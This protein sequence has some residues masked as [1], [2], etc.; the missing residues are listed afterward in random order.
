[1]KN[2]NNILIL[3]SIII[4]VF[5]F[6]NC[7]NLDMFIDQQKPSTN[8]KW[9][10]NEKTNTYQNDLIGKFKDSQVIKEFTNESTG[11]KLQIIN[12]TLWVKSEYNS[13][14]EYQIF[15]T[16]Q[17]ENTFSL[18][19]GYK[20]NNS[21]NN[22]SH[23]ILFNKKLEYGIY[24]AKTNK[25]WELKTRSLVDLKIVDNTIIVGIPLSEIRI[26][27]IANV[28]FGY[29]D[30]KSKHLINIGTNLDISY[31]YNTNTQM[32][33]YEYRQISL[34]NE[35]SFNIFQGIEDTIIAYTSNLLSGQDTIIELYDATGTLLDSNDDYLD[36][37]SQIDYKVN[38]DGI[39]IIKV[40]S[41][42]NRYI[43][44]YDLSLF[45]TSPEK[46]SFDTN[47]FTEGF[48][49]Q[50][51]TTKW[52]LSSSNAPTIQTDYK[53]SGSRSLK[54]TAGNNGISYASINVTLQTTGVLSFYYRVSSEY[55]YDTFSLYINNELV[56]KWSGENGQFVYFE[57]KFKRAG[58]Y[59]IKWEYK[60]DAD[61]TGYLD[62]QYIDVINIVQN[63][64]PVQT[65][66][67]FTEGFEN[68]LTSLPWILG[69]H[70]QPY[71]TTD[72][73]NSGSK[74]IRFGNITNNQT[75]YFQITI[76]L[77]QPQI[78][79]F[80][81]RLSSEKNRDYM[82]LYINNTWVKS[83]SG[84]QTT[85]E[86]Y[87]YQ[88][89]QGTHTIKISYNKDG[90]TQQYQDTCFIDDISVTYQQQ[91]QPPEN[92]TYVSPA[93]DTHD[94][95]TNTVTFV[96]NKSNR[97]T[98]YDVY[99]KKVMESNYRL[100]ANVVQPQTSTVS[101]TYR[102]AT[103]EYYTQYQWKIVQKNSQG[104]NS[105][106]YI[107]TFITK[108]NTQPQTQSIL[109]EG[110]ETG[111]FSKY[112]WVLS[113]NQ[114][115]T[116]QS[117]VKK[118]GNYQMKFGAITHSQQS[119][120]S[121]TVKPTEK[122]TL[123]FWY[124]V[125]SEKYYDKFNFKINNSIKKTDYGNNDWVYYSCILEQNTEYVLLFEYIKDHSVNSY[126]DSQWVDDIKIEKLESG[127]TGNLDFEGPLYYGNVLLVTNQSSDIT[128]S[129]STGSLTSIQE[130]IE[131][132]AELYPDDIYQL[133][134]IRDIK[135]EDRN[136]SIAYSTISE[137]A[138]VG[139]T[140]K[141]WV[142]NFKTYQDYQIT[143][144]L[145]QVNSTCEVWVESTTDINTA[146]QNS[147]QNE[148][149]NRI[150]PNVSQYF[151][152]PSDIDS[153]VKTAIL[154]Y[155]IQD[156][157]SGSG[158]Y[159]GGYF[160]GGDL[161]NIQY[162]N[163][164][165]LINIDTYPQMKTSTTGTCDVQKAYSTIQHEFQ[166]LVNFNRNFIIEGNGQMHTSLDEGLAMQQ[167]HLIYGTLTSRIS[168]FNSTENVQS[169]TQWNSDLYSY[170]LSYLFMQYFKQQTTNNN[171]IFKML[172]EHQYNDFRAV[173]QL[174]KQYNTSIGNFQNL[175]IYFRIQ[176]ALKESTG[177]YGFKSSQFNSISIRYKNT[178]SSITLK[179]GQ[180]FYKQLSSGYFTETGSQ[181]SNI[182]FVGIT[183]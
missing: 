51:D 33:S 107:Y 11:T 28:L 13:K 14:Y 29:Y 115:P 112:T 78:F 121:I 176:L 30:G 156:G 82:R 133:N 153:N 169:P 7:T 27:S 175:M 73:K 18:K 60:K 183:K 21:V 75:S 8:F 157:F 36:V 139:D 58:T 150:Y 172:I 24:K 118:S 96:W 125:S 67:E 31:S 92:F 69:G 93:N 148:F 105:S 22:V 62:R 108:Q 101:Y 163:R 50:L 35:K 4:L 81:N 171:N 76:T 167:E 10:L 39:Y 174:V 111:N 5:I 90:S 110:F 177:N 165:E 64:L 160:Y 3:F 180:A 16:N 124:K 42:G 34:D 38:Q 20:L 59:T 106:S 143:A 48:E 88:L 19:D 181:G 54:F 135:E 86:K 179:G 170:A 131:E 114:N 68:G 87:E 138:N 77:T 47:I 52:S 1:M 178:T 141:F 158:G 134:P 127:A 61:T 129:Q 66:G 145:Q 142:Y 109:E 173:D 102:S 71:I 98:S 26:D 104:T 128:N 164:M 17:S 140:K 63:S 162:S 152:T 132:S 53:K 99:I 9:S 123:S 113:G 85:F 159:I 147:I 95:D 57:Y 84:L 103:L 70:S 72:Y 40:K 122:S 136:Q 182:K 137:R 25:T 119:R 154:C 44:Y 49:S 117:T 55:G 116:V 79:S 56:S 6:T 130:I 120:A 74:S 155:D 41:W 89:Q 126:S 45:T 37:S 97:Q 151:Y 32:D 12:D 43:G 15:I 2:K 168:T 83:W 146:K 161:L 149:N 166:H 65:V 23:M 94:V 91:V 80:Y 46:Y 144:T 100:I